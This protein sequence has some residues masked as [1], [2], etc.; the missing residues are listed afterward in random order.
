[1]WNI[2]YQIQHQTDSILCNN[3]LPNGEL[4]DSEWVLSFKLID[5]INE[6]IKKPYEE[7]EICIRYQQI[8]K[9]NITAMKIL[10]PPMI[11]SKHYYLVFH[12]A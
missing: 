10:P 11:S 7:N 1:M 4:S 6:I 5:E 3:H 12:V 8:G 2:F 9:Q